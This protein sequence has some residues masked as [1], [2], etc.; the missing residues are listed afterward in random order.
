[1]A[2]L[3]ADELAKEANQYRADLDA[4]KAALV[5]SREEMAQL[6]GSPLAASRIVAQYLE[7][8]EAGGTATDVRCAL[9]AVV[10]LDSEATLRMAEA[11]DATAKAH[12]QASEIETYRAQRDENAKRADQVE[13]TLQSTFDVAKALVREVGGLTLSMLPP[14]GYGVGLARAYGEAKEQLAL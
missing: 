1:M 10:A 5:L 9:D 4:I 12:Q 6:D 7:H 8:A 14:G 13:A 2:Q 11:R 3:R